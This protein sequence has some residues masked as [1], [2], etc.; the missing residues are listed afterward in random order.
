MATIIVPAHNE[1]TVI[2]KCLD[3]L[4][5]QAGVDCIIVACNG[6]TDNTAAIV[7]QEYPDLICLDI[8]TP[9]KVNA[10]NEAEKY[11]VSW[12]VFYIDADTQL[13]ENAIQI[14]TRA[15]QIGP[16]LL[17][18][19]EPVIDTSQ[20]SWWVKQYYRIWLS[21]PYIQAGVVAT[22]S[23]VIAEQGRKRFT[24]FPPVINDDGFVRCQFSPHERGNVSGAKV[25]INAPRTLAS[26]IKI[27]TRARLGNMQLAASNLCT[28]PD[29]KPYSRILKQKLF[30]REW[31]A[32]GVYIA[33]ASLIRVRAWHQY[34]NLNQYRW[35][36]DKTSRQSSS[37]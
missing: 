10:L 1:A 9:S 19:P 33:I 36:V 13:S 16:L 23:F 26:L 21:L 18:A 12:P 3:S 8:A 4:K 24:E 37:T 20:S 5:K 32:A 11:I 34:K 6:C 25:Y 27:K 14:I 22:C 30:S 28:R 17:A 29:A 35:E 31:L 7:Q 2:R 15:M